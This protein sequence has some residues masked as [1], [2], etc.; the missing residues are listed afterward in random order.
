MSTRYFRAG[1][2]TIIYR[3]TGAI[4]I[5]KRAQPPIGVWELQQGGI[6]LGEFAE[7]TLWR[8][9]EEEVGLKRDAIATVT[10]MPGWTIYQNPASIENSAL[11][12][13]GQSH[14]WFFLLLKPECE[15]DLTNALEDEASEWRWSDFNELISLTGDHKLHV[16]QTL[17]DYF[18]EHV[19]P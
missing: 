14:T 16:Y 1:V 11:P 10:K 8:E 7:D 9:L 19:L 17:K 2:G 6:D 4:A 3:E 5:F 18:T 15:I 13:L 12:V